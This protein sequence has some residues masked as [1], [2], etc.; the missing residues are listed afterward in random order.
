MEKYT[1]FPAFFLNS[2][3]PPHL[4][5]SALWLGVVHAEAYN[6]LSGLRDRRK[7]PDALQ[8]Q[9]LALEERAVR[10]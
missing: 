4:S 1:A 2:A 10:Q 9:R 6:V 5:A 8:R 7:Q 3:S